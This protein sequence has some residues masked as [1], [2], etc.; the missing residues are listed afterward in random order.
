MQSALKDDEKEDGKDN[1]GHTSTNVAKRVAALAMVGH[2]NVNC[3][4]SSFKWFPSSAT[5]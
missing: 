4:M 3:D 1:D 2:G 5:W